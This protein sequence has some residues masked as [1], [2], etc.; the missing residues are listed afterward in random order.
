MLDALLGSSDDRK[1]IVCPI[2]T[3]VLVRKRE[4]DGLVHLSNCV[5]SKEVERQLQNV[6]QTRLGRRAWLL[7]AT[8]ACVDSYHNGRCKP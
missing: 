2:G 6:H 8:R 3:L 7:M 4:M 1:T 5:L